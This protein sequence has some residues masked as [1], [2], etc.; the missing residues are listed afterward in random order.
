MA[1]SLADVLG[2][3][4]GDIHVVPNVVEVDA[5]RAADARSARWLGPLVLG[6]DRVAMLT[7]QSPST[8]FALFRRPAQEPAPVDVP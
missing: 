6:L 7:G 5:F 8:K 2:V 4:A 3:S 1:R